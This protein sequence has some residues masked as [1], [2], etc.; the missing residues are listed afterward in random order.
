MQIGEYRINKQLHQGKHFTVYS[1][2]GKE[3]E[4]HCILKVLNKS[5]LG[6][7][8]LNAIENE[9]RLLRKVA[10]EYVI[11]TLELI[12]YN[13]EYYFLV[14]EDIK[15]QTLKAFLKNKVDASPAPF[16]IRQFLKLAV[17][18]TDG[19]AAVHKQ[20]IVHKDINPSN[21]IWNPETG[22][23]KIIDFDIAV[24]YDIKTS[25]LGNPER[26]AGTL[27]YISPEQTGRMNR[28]VDQRSD[29]Y[30]LGVTFYEMLTGKL[31]FEKRDPM[32]IVYA[33]L[34]IDPEF[35]HLFNDQVPEI[36]S[37]IVL[38]LL[39]K[40][41]EDR[42]QSAEGLKHDL[43]KL[44]EPGSIG[45]KKLEAFTLGSED[46]PGKLQI[47]EKL[48]GREREIE[49]L[50]AAYKRVAQGTSEMVLVAGY[51]GTGKTAL[52][53][54]IHK[55]ITHDKSYFIHGK[56]EQLQKNIPYFAF[57][58]A[59]EQFC[60]LLLTE[61]KAVLDEWKQT[62][63]E[64]VGNL[65]KVLTD[66]IPNL[67]HVIGKQPDV[68]QIGGTEAKNRLNYVFS[69]IIHTISTEE[70]PL[71]I[72]ID[73]LQWADYA[74]LE[75]LKFLISESQN[76]YLLFLGA[77]R[78]NEVSSTHILMVIVEELRKKKVTISTIPVKNLKKNN[79]EN[80]LKDTLRGSNP[81][82]R[83]DIEKL[84]NHIY[85][86][87][88]GNAFFTIQFLENLYKEN[89]L[90]FDS[91]QSRW[92]W[93]IKEIDRLDI[94][95]NVVD[96]LLHRIKSLSTDV[97]EVLKFA[98]CS[99]NIFDL[100]NLSV[101]A[102]KDIQIRESLEIALREIL[103]YPID[104]RRYRFIHDRVQQ[105]AYALISEEDKKPV[106]LKI[107][108]LLLEEFHLLE[109][110]KTLKTIKEAEV[111]IFDIANHFNIAIDLINVESEKIKVLR[112]NLKAAKKAAAATAYQTGWEYI[113]K[114]LL[115][116]PNDGWKKHYDL[117]LSVYNEAIQLAYLSSTYAEINRLGD[118]VL[119]FA[120]KIMDKSTVYE[121]QIMGLI[122]QN[123]F[124]EAVNIALDVMG[125]LGIDIPNKPNESDMAILTKTKAL[126]EKK[127][128]QGMEKLPL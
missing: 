16:D 84:S 48:Y 31:P 43:K 68:P 83:Q 19:L 1:A 20:N 17:A 74:S 72:F 71:V 61:D 6:T 24:E 13:D 7:P 36:L 27:P 112:L 33:H 34:A 54:E 76:R 73:D 26:L 98:S 32:E 22:K 69:R 105:A 52:V 85:H 58:K 66:I 120:S 30:S 3:D 82:D 114:A 96:L 127:G 62:I 42:Y 23:I 118:I 59:I 124:E 29:L 2:V 25:Y 46:F 104:H 122:A 63:L 9:Y 97:Q 47:P 80:L 14:L 116:L 12:H 37:R 107:G 126:L 91:S 78:D 75:L 57:I 109:E 87:T 45:L 117:T 88:H 93:D 110:S 119:A 106:H 115:L 4:L 99:G 8:G 100:E 18:I 95:D 60:D 77:F 123:Q 86:K 53:N 11:K 92:E 81:P 40:N 35:P 67:E 101:I 28:R 10:S 111:R 89:L 51:S 90:T 56:F 50:L 65:G 70:H 113:Q 64:A 41:P 103:I 94:T 55:Q 102:G 5:H 128:L 49:Q 44:Q 125:R 108:R 38:K 39:A 79:I 15:G 21:I 121:Y